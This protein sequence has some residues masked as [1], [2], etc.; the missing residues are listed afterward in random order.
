MSTASIGQPELHPGRKA[1][2]A[3][4]VG[5]VLEW[6]DFGVY[7]YFASYIAAVFF[8]EDDELT[9]LLAAFLTFGVGF[10]ARPIG[11]VVLGRL[12]DMRGRRAALLVSVFIM[13]IATLAI[14][15]LPT[16]ATV[17]ELAPVLLVLGRLAQGFSA[18]GE[19]GSSTSLII[20][21][22]PPGRRGL[23]GSLQQMSV[24]TGLLLGAGVAALLNARLSQEAVMAWGWRVP[25]LAGGVLGLVGFYM[26]RA[27]DETP[28]YTRMKSATIRPLE[29]SGLQLAIRAFG[30]TIVWT[31]CFYVLMA[32]MPTWS[33]RY[34]KLPAADA[35]WANTIGLV[36]L[37]AAIPLMGHLS[38]RLGRKPM[39][40]G[41]CIAF[42][43]LPLPVFRL[44]ASGT[45]SFAAFLTVQ[46]VCAVLIAVFA[47]TAPAAIAEIFPTRRRS[48]WMATS[49]ALAV[50]VFGGFSPYMSVWLI[51]SFGSPIA[52]GFYLMG[53]AL[54][55]LSI[56]WTL[57][58]TAFEDD[59][60]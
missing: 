4:V 39:L 12:G 30:V 40:I 49:Y 20:E 36:V 27:I 53:A 25:F 10:L 45:A 44:L 23:Y 51:G 24:A 3:A 32:Y 16:Y 13:A 50:A 33:Q 31:V 7:S 41:G 11:A 8:E 21:W 47:G 55:S 17:G 29:D 42:L 57:E 52:H 60:A 38:D 18:G 19:W 48:V 6:Y 5:N 14:G 28:A 58:E 34:M 2:A 15:L 46:A 59:L 22:A 56:I 43:I 54:V 1:V 37:V 26:R 9:A 35:L